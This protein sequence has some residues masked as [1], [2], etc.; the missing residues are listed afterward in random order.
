MA[1]GL[2]FQSF[3]R[4]TKT[5]RVTS[6]LSRRGAERRSTG[7]L[8]FFLP[9]PQLPEELSVL[10][11]VALGRAPCGDPLQV[12]G[13]APRDFDRVRQTQSIVPVIEGRQPVEVRVG[14]GARGAPDVDGGDP[15][16]SPC[17]RRQSRAG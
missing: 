12:H 10:V 3:A 7:T 15:P 16:A 17:S 14:G 1:L 2:V 11:D 13:A 4:P 6:A 9:P 8:H 5:T